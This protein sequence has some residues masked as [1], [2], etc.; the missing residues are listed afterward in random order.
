MRQKVIDYDR[1]KAT[2]DA[3]LLWRT[4][5]GMRSY[6]IYRDVDDASIVTTIQEWDS[7]EVAQLHAQSPELRR[8][9]QDAGV[10][11]EPMIYIMNELAAEKTN[12]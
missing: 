4:Q 3:N 7:F 1:W 12:F 6:R 9:L 2:F 8:K 10:I 11:G 5:S